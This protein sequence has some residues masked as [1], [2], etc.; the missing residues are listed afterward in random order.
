MITTDSKRHADTT[1][2]PLA[3]MEVFFLPLL[4][5]YRQ[6]KAFLSNNC[7]LLRVLAGETEQRNS[8]F[9]VK[10]VQ[11]SYTLVVS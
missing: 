3:W 11:H 10:K 7:K 2:R 5:V 1:T 4:I 9:N 8:C 6:T